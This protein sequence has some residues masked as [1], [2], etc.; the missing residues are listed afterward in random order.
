MSDFFSLRPDWDH[1]MPIHGKVI[2][3]VSWWTKNSPKSEGFSQPS[4][5]L[6]KEWAIDEV[7]SGQVA[8][9]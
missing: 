8:T 9:S 5:L 3:M 7:D 1:S 2:Q 6:S 4:I